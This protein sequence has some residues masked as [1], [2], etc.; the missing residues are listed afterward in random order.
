MGDFNSRT[1]KLPDFI[2]ND[3]D[4]HTPVP[5]YY[6]SDEK[7]LLHLR[8]NEDISSSNEYG[9][10]LLDMCKELQLR[11][12]NGRTMGD[13][14][15]KLT[16]YKWNGSSTVDYGLVES[17]ILQNVEFFKV[18]DLMGHL[19]DHCII[20]LGFKCKFKC[21][22]T[23]SH[24][25]YELKPNFCWNSQSEYIFKA[26]LSSDD[27]MGKINNI[28][29]TDKN[30]DIE[31]M[32]E[33]VNNVL[34]SAAESALRKKKLS[35][36]SSKKKKKW[37]DRDC[38][39]LR[40]EVIRLGRKLCRS[41]IT[42][43]QRLVFFKKKKELKKIIK[44]KKNLFRQSILTQLSNLSENNPKQYWNLVKELKELDADSS[45]NKTPVASEE[46]IKHFSNLLLSKNQE[47]CTELEKLIKEMSATSTF[48][49][50]DF[51]ITQEEIK[52]A[53]RK[54]KPGKA[55]G[56]DK[57]S[58]EMLKASTSSLLQ[59]YEKLFNSLFRKGIYPNCWRESYIVPI[60]KSGSRADPS[61]YRG[62]AINS[63]LGKVFSIVLKNR[64]EVFVKD[65]NLIDDTQ[66]GFKKDC[67]TV[68]HMFILRALLDKYIKK[69]K[70][71]LYVCFVDFKKAYDSV[72][73]QALMY[74]LLKQ[75]IGG[76]FFTV[77]RSMYVNND[78]CIKINNS[79]RSSF[80]S[81]NVGVR[82]GD[83]ISPILFNLYVSDLQK[84]LGTDNDTPVLETTSVNCLM[85]ADD[86]VLISRSE[87]GLQRLVDR[88]SEYCCQW[89]MEVNTDKTKVIKFSGN[90][91]RC[92]TTFFYKG[93]PIE[94]VLK[95]KYLGIEF[96]SSGTWS[97]AIENLSSRGLKALFSLQ[98][99]VCTANISPVLGLKLF[100]QM[101]KPILCY[102]SEL[103]SAFDSNKKKFQ[104]ADA[105]AN[106]LDNLC[107]EK[108]H[109][110]F[111]KFLLGVNKRAVN[112]AVKG[113]LGRFP[114]GISCMLQALKYWN[115]L[116]ESNN[117]L[118]KEAVIVCQ[119]LDKDGIFTWFSFYRNLCKAI[120]TNPE[121]ISNDS[122]VSLK[123]KLCNKFVD[124]WHKTLHGFSKM[125][126]Y[127]SFK[128]KFCFERYLVTV[129][130]RAHRVIYTKM[131]ISNHRLAVETGRFHKI[132]R[133]E[134]V[135]IYC[136]NIGISQVEDEKHVLLQCERF[137]GIRKE[138]LH[139]LQTTCP[140]FN[141]LRDEDRFN[142]LLNSDGPIV[143]AVAKFYHQAYKMC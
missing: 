21:N 135:C 129:G 30:T 141:I 123:V 97:N 47:N 109:V 48:T 61:N 118:L 105:I 16:C 132:P 43:E 53:I 130:N 104:T 84:F 40:R 122:V 128:D 127:S 44:L 106:Y 124:Y 75:N 120:D 68:D 3:D 117:S 63:T 142:F 34:N 125:D 79:Q 115:H 76:M 62:I 95:Y 98:R 136:K 24:G 55:S 137:E 70:S 85:Y 91:H 46:W 67:R 66:I 27:I 19:S 99:C 11:I 58:A 83:V 86:L 81:S 60:F 36:N 108:V 1:L 56:L 8:Q 9:K 74:K 35:K 7:E 134:R 90:G 92:K 18:H 143:K 71:P 41:S 140:N 29:H 25:I 20:S 77:L 37:F 138:L 23:E 101:I 33:S 114:I 39:T 54:L 82:Q 2:I 89:K 45:S 139:L 51:R 73:R 57:I 52:Q 133:N 69:L 87:V 10:R 64:L 126:T 4:K 121:V 72:W 102:G 103:W 107:I 80:F 15:G 111:C 94:N 28:L 12:L 6:V 32:T 42:H 17:D 22:V 50:L 119:D 100:D 5:D 49:T 110:K 112:L 38:F 96:C 31:E 78:M 88:L 93:N 113:E 59:V 116:Q 14:N 65:N 131:R 13:L 26:T